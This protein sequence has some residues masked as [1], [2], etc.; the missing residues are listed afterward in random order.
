MSESVASTHPWKNKARLVLNGG[1]ANR[2]SLRSFRFLFL[3][4]Y[5][6]YVFKQDL[7]YEKTNWK[8]GG[9]LII[10]EYADNDSTIKIFQECLSLS[11][12]FFLYIFFFF[13]V[14]LRVI[15]S[16]HVRNIAMMRVLSCIIFGGYG[17]FEQRTIRSL[18]MGTKWISKESL[19]SLLF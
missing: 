13:F 9:T 16:I 1:A 6:T 19:S 8:Y 5:L 3:P 10:R 14:K 7:E 18:P 15:K 4:Q 12:A 11:I 17:V 2:F